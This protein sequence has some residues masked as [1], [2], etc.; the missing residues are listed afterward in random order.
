MNHQLILAFNLLIILSLPLRAELPA[1]PV[2]MFHPGSKIYFYGVRAEHFKCNNRDVDVFLPLKKAPTA[3]SENFPVIVY[4]HGQALG[5]DHYR[6]TLEHLAQKGI[7]AIFPNY[8]KGFFDRDWRRMGRDYVTLTE[9][10]LKKI[11]E[12]FDVLTA[13]DQIVFSGHSKGA[14]VASVAAGVAFLE[15]LPVKPRSI[16]LFEAAGVDK[17]S[18]EVIDS[19]VNLT[20]VYSD[21]DKIVSR[22]ISEDIYT[23]TPSIR[24]QFIFLKSYPELGANHFWP[25]TK[26]SIV[27]G[28][29]ESSYHY[30]SAWKWLVAAAFDL[31][32]GGHADNVY[33]YG[34]QTTDKGIVGFHDDLKRNW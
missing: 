31:K 1:S 7:V 18:N 10:A 16:L 25:L 21:K 8:D 13:S 20:V 3:E 23:S 33:L 15:S 17:K 32:T 2:D 11:N 30:F 5:M 34:D 19:N 22:D 12:D 14:Y 4:G 24:K 9:C 27:G 28:G 29:T 26:S 6:L